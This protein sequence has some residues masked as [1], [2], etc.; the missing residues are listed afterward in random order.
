MLQ[1]I[2]VTSHMYFFL[3]THGQELYST[4]LEAFFCL[5]SLPL[6]VSDYAKGARW[7]LMLMF[8]RPLVRVGSSYV[9]VMSLFSPHLRLMLV[10]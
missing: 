5:V 10:G 4:Y 7:H 2:Y 6:H 9:A 1:T 3:Y 8:E